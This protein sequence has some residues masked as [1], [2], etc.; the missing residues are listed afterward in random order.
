MFHSVPLDVAAE[1][2]SISQRR[3]ASLRRLLVKCGLSAGSYLATG[4]YVVPEMPDCAVAP[5]E[6]VECRQ[7]LASYDK[8][9]ALKPD[10]AEAHMNQSLCLLQTGRFEQGW[11]QHEWRKKLD[12]AFRSYPQPVWLGEE[13]IAGKTLFIYSEQ[14]LGDTIQF[15]RYVKLMEARGAIVIISVQQ[16]VRRLL[17]QISPTIQIIDPY[18]TP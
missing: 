16:P 4:I 18:E 3:E 2:R 11:R 5:H 8:A 15:C 1:R 10:D 9:I 7:A 6:Y 17:K 12:N 13:N 14:R